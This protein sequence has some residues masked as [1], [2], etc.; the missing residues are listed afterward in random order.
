MLKRFGRWPVLGV[1]L[2][3]NSIPQKDKLRAIEAIIVFEELEVVSGGK[4]TKKTYLSL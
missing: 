3:E 4:D 1:Y 2:S